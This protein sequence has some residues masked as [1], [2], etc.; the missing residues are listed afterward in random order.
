MK[1]NRPLI[2]GITGGIGSGKTEF[3]N[4]LRQLNIPVIDADVVSKELVKKDKKIQQRL[5]SI[6][7]EAIFTKTGKL[8]RN[9]LG[10]IAFT[11]RTALDRLDQVMQVP[12]N[13]S[14]QNRIQSLVDSKSPK[15]IGI[16][17]ATLYESGMDSICDKTVVVDAP[18]KK[19]YE[20]LSKTRKWKKEKITARMK[21]QWDV[22]EKKRC[23]DIVIE[24]LDDVQ[25]LHEKANMTL[26][27]LLEEME[28]RSPMGKNHRGGGK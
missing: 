19:R 28:S 16:D 24:N 9:V 1:M 18:K 4:G 15:I 21:W 25:K 3:S 14:I 11:D 20:W 10:E 27:H 17:M 12:L 13:Q 2:L 7:G 6:F 5:K 23:A 22:D 26:K 8:K